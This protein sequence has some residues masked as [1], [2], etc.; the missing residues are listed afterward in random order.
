VPGP[1]PSG[2]TLTCDAGAIASAASPIVTIIVRPTKPGTITLTANVFADQPDPNRT[3]NSAA[4]TTT[5]TR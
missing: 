5:V 1:G 4:E 3:D 2:G